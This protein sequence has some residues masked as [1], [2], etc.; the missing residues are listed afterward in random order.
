VHVAATQSVAG[1]AASSETS[2]A[3]LKWIKATFN[4][5]QI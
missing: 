5:Y 3:K 1:A 4:F 2:N